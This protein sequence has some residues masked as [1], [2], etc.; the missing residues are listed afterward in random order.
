MIDLHNHILPGVDDGAVGLDESL[1]IARQFVAEGVTCVA[2]TPHLDPLNGNGAPPPVVDEQLHRVRRALADAGIPL[3]VWRGQ[4]LFLTPEAPDLLE[5]GAALCLGDSEAVLVEVSMV[6]HRR[7]VY[8]DETLFRMQLAG[9]I[10]VLAHPERYPFVTRDPGALDD[11]ISRG[12]F[13]QLTAG[14]LLGEKGG[15]IRR[16][17]ERLLR[18]GAYALAASDRHHPG[19]E[20][21]LAEMHARIA[22]LVDSD[23]ADLLLT[24]NPRRLLDGLELLMPPRVEAEQRSFLGRI[25]G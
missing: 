5:R 21:S 24:T 6:A 17:A 8:M 14:P 10:P 11:L 16:T 12:I 4:E 19:P 20:R 23:A 15:Q 7:P 9:Y 1:D 25:F 22:E 2:A 3:E 13:L 18:R